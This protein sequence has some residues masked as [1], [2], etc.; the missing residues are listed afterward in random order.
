[1]S[2]SAYIIGRQRIIRR[3]VIKH[4]MKH[5]LLQCFDDVFEVAKFQEVKN[6]AHD[7]RFPI[8]SDF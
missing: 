5:L 1:M 2:L 3:T 7:K 8:N 4:P 6:K